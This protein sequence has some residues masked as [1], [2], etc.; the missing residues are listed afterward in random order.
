V[1]GGKKKCGWVGGKCQK[2]GASARRCGQLLE[3]VGECQKVGAS[4]GGCWQMGVSASRWGQLLVDEDKQKK[5]SRNAL[6]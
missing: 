3:G 4:A 6:D 2:V 1:L 5:I